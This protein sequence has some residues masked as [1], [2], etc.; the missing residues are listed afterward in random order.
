MVNWVTAQTLTHFTPGDVSGLTNGAAAIA[1]SGAHTC[2]VTNMGGVK[3][4]GSNDSGQLGDGTLTDRMTPVNVTGLTSDVATIATG[5]AHTCA[6]TTTDGVKC[7][8]DNEVGQLGDGTT[9]QRLSPVDV[10]GLTSGVMAIAAGGDRTCALTNA[11]GVKC[12][13]ENGYGQLGDGTTTDRLT[14]VDVNGLTS[15]VSAIAAGSYHT[16][17]VTNAGSVKCWGYNEFGQLGDGTRTKRLTP[18][19]VGGLTSDVMMVAAGDYHT[20]ALTN[21]GSVK[22]WGKNNYSQLGD[23]T[24]TPHL[25]PVDVNGLTTGV[26]TIAAGTNHAC[27]ITTMGGLRC[28]GWNGVGQL[29]DGTSIQPLTPVDVNGLANGV[30]AVAVGSV[31]TCALTDAGGVKCWGQ[32]NSGQLGNGEPAYRTTPVDVVGLDKYLITG[33]VRDGRNVPIVGVAISTTLGTALTDASG[34][35]TVTNLSSGAYTIAPVG[36]YIFLPASRTINVP[37]DAIGQDFVAYTV[38]KEVTPNTVSAV[39]FGDVFTYTLNLITPNSSTFILSDHVPTYTSYISGSLVAPAGIAY[40]SLSNV[41]SGTLD[42]TASVPST[43]S[44]AVRVEITGTVDFAP[45]ITNRACVYPEGSGLADCLWS[46]EVWKFTYV[47]P[48]YL[49]AVL[50]ND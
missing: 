21:A 20:C 4:W 46:N 18:V 31:H 11:G 23:G 22:C 40:D 7:W 13:G 50:R 44:F 6:L 34:T 5:G 38:F 32:N 16:C 10:N 8:G 48:T 2:A 17:A 9:T 37:P 24:T 35:Y 49:P 15:G 26:M 1:T 36:G 28:W 27:G 42:L 47:W 45:L 43:V 14:P 29:G 33:Q 39:N 25:T 3:C 41:I 19:D 12:W 30:R